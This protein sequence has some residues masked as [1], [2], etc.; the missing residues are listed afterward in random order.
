MIESTFFGIPF[1]LLNA[2]RELSLTE[3][4]ELK[5]LAIERVERKQLAAL[6]EKYES[7]E[8]E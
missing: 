3:I 2:L 4:E 8:N 5:A 7:Q 6:K 1:S